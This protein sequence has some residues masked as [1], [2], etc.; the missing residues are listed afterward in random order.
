MSILWKG[1]LEGEPLQLGDLQLDI[2]ANYLLNRMM[3]QVLQPKQWTGNTWKSLKIT[4]CIKVDP[5]Q[6]G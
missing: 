3:L 1:L 2:V 4:M 6:N 5:L